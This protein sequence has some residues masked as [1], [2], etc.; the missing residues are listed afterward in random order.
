MGTVLGHLRRSAE[1]EGIR[2]VVVALFGLFLISSPGLGAVAGRRGEALPPRSV[3]MG[4]RPAWSRD[5]LHGGEA[6]EAGQLVPLPI[7]L[8]PAV[9]LHV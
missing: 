1:A 2:V 4:V 9:T 7:T 6:G 8:T 3:E 5:R